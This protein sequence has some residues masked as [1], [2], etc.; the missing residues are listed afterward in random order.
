MQQGFP[1]FTETCHFCC[2][3]AGRVGDAIVGTHSEDKTCNLWVVVQVTVMKSSIASF[4]LIRKT[5]M[6]RDVSS[7][8]DKTLGSFIYTCTYIPGIDIC[9]SL[10]K[11]FCQS[12]MT[13]LAGNNQQ[14]IA[15]FVSNVD[16]KGVA[17]QVLLE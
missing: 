15:E 7:R 3:Q 16:V 4:L 14:G 12:S 1:D 8:E 2:S 9:P 13:I 6:M 10:E 5:E 17:V 11:R